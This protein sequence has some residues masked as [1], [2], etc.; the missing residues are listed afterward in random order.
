MRSVLIVA[1]IIF[2]AFVF[3]S[4]AFALK[5]LVMWLVDKGEIKLYKALHLRAMDRALGN[6]YGTTAMRQKLDQRDGY[7]P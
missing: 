5:A 6:P 1:E 3:W 7:G 4:V 2:G